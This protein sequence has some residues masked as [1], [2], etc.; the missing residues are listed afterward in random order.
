M[1]ASRRVN[2]C[3][4][5]AP[6]EH[7]RQRVTD[8]SAMDVPSYT[9]LPKVGGNGSMGVTAPCNLPLRARSCTVRLKNLTSRATGRWHCLTARDSIHHRVASHADPYHTVQVQHSAVQ[10]S[11]PPAKRLLGSQSWPQRRR[12][13]LG[14][15]AAMWVEPTLAGHS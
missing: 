12:A 2:E 6:T 9:V 15:L 3:E 11:G 14:A 5:T 7:S 8:T 10:E 1:A 13:Y 4:H